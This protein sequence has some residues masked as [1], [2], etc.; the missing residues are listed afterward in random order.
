MSVQPSVTGTTGHGEEPIVCTLDAAGFGAQSDRW[1]QL[2]ASAGVE[3]VEIEDGVRVHFRAGAGIEHE[4]R[5][6]V[7]VETEC[8]SWASWTVQPEVG[9]LILRI[10]SSGD[11]IAVIHRMFIGASPAPTDGCGDCAG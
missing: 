7:A 10:R 3:R 5:E 8:C 11:G 1:A 2:L 4:L 6:L 9:Q